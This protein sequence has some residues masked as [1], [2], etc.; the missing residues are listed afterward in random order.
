MPHARAPVRPPASA[1]PDA[2]AGV[3]LLL[4][5]RRPLG[6][7]TPPG[8]LR[9]QPHGVSPT[10]LPMSQRPAP[11]GSAGAPSVRPG[12]PAPWGGCPGTR[13][14]LALGNPRPSGSGRSA[15]RQRGGGRG[16]GCPLD[17]RAGSEM[18]P[19]RTPR[20]ARGVQGQA[21]REAATTSVTSGLSTSPLSPGPSC[22]GVTPRG[23][24]GAA[25]AALSRPSPVL[26]EDPPGPRVDSPLE[27]PSPSRR[28]C[29]AA[30][31][32]GRGRATC[33]PPPPRGHR[34]VARVVSW[35]EPPGSGLASLRWAS[36]PR[37]SVSLGA[38][39]A[40]DQPG[41]G[42]RPQRR[43]QTRGG[44]FGFKQPQR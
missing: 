27:W 44:L 28:S 34:S 1:G 43:R 30:P 29:P 33:R 16:P 42:L 36:L 37:P 35:R 40:P 13:A 24:G 19:G 23:R 4:H 41:T 11:L 26:S 22:S 25:S 6:P 15:G 32:E 12:F 17:R 39:C 10:R 9:G 18:L 31:R 14:A 38:A 7:E 20:R 21:P 5:V 3:C 2:A 8:T